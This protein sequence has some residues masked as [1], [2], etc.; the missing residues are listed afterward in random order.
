MNNFQEELLIEFEEVFMLLHNLPDAVDEL[1][2]YRR[3]IL[4]A[5][6]VGA[7]AEA[8]NDSENFH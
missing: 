4:V 6:V 8:L 2:E 7:V 5:M 1:Q 3:A